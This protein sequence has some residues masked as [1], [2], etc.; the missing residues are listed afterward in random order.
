MSYQD[1]TMVKQAY[2]PLLHTQHTPTEARSQW[3]LAQ[4]KS[5]NFWPWKHTKSHTWMAIWYR[6]SMHMMLLYTLPE[7]QF[8][9]WQTTP[10]LMT[11]FPDWRLPLVISHWH[12][13]TERPGQ[14][15]YLSSIT[16]QG[17]VLLNWI[18]IVG[19]ENYQER[20]NECQMCQ[21][22]E[23][24]TPCLLVAAWSMIS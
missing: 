10:I 1:I 3:K 15:D 11:S 19:Y 14:S 2:Q 16:K 6:I 22:H 18:N 17:N 9:H 21:L 5:R 7:L 20:V 24:K 4:Y 8:D 23:K 13:L 12:F